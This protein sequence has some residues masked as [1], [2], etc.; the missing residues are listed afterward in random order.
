MSPLL[1][2]RTRTRWSRAA[3]LLIGAAALAAYLVPR[4]LTPHAPWPM[5]NVAVYWWGGSHALHDAT[6]YAA[7]EPESFT[8]PPFAAALFG[9]AGGV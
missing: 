8:Y 6:L 2:S 7:H 5:W 4:L 3:V 9:L 1:P